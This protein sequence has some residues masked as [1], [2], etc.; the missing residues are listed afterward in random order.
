M[1]EAESTPLLALYH[2]TMRDFSVAYGDDAILRGMATVPWITYVDACL[3]EKRLLTMNREVRISPLDSCYH[4]LMK[5]EFNT[6]PTGAIAS[7]DYLWQ[8]AT[9]DV[10]AFELPTPPENYAAKL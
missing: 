7:P 4:R 3:L 10:V 9:P 8:E 6:H 2:E 1:G 5:S